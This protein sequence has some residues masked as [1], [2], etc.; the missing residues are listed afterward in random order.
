MCS[1][2]AL[3]AT[4]GCGSHSAVAPRG[5]SL[6]LSLDAPTRVTAG[7]PARFTLRLKNTASQPVPVMLA[8]RPA[9]DFAVS[10]PDGT[11][12][13]RWST[14]RVIPMLLET[15]TLSPGDEFECAA[16]GPITDGRGTV[17]APGRY[18]LIGVLNMDPP[19]KMTTAPQDLV[20]TSP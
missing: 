10:T 13:W 5:D 17:I 9:C 19:E 7:T 1:V 2:A 3:V 11:E 20:L 6:A 18:R 8:G 16:E 4:F 15:R 12:V 14:G